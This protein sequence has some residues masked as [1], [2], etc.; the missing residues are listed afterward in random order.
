MLVPCANNKCLHAVAEVCVPNQK[1]VSVGEYRKSMMHLPYTDKETQRRQPYKFPVQGI[2]KNVP[3]VRRL[4]F[5]ENNVSQL[6]D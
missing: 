1:T 2:L 4:H 5:R 6:P 3:T